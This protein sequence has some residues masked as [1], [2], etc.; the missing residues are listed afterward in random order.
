MAPR[1]YLARK[2][3]RELLAAAKVKS[4][5]VPVEMLASLV[6]AEIR[7]EPFPGSLSGMVHRQPNGAAVIGINSLHPL[8]RQ[9]FSIAH[10]LAHLFLHKDEALHVDETS[11]I[12]FR[13]ELS[14][15]AIDASEIE[16]NQFAAELLMPS[17]LLFSEI[18]KLPDDLGTEEAVAK[19]AEQFQVSEQAMTFR[20]SGLG[21]LR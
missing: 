18:D 17:K 15:R 20:L 9:R 21:V 11:S 16:A 14:S 8:T 5:P 2:K 6:G 19:L 4:P 7:Y 10:E 13:S 3:A 1:N 12:R